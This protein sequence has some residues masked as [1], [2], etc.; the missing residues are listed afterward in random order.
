MSLTDPKKM[1]KNMQ[2]W[3]LLR[4]A[5]AANFNQNQN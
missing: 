2:K 1:K 3:S 4:M 5:K